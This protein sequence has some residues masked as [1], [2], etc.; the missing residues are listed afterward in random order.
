MTDAINKHNKS[1]SNI[2]LHFIINIKMISIIALCVAFFLTVIFVDRLV[3]RRLRV[4]RIAQKAIL[5][6]GCDSGF[7]F[8]LALKCLDNGMTVFASC[9]TQQ[10]VDLLQSKSVKTATGR[11][12]AFIMDVTSDISVQRGVTFVEKTLEET[13]QDLYNLINN[14]G[15]LGNSAF[16]D[17]LR[18]ED[19]KEVVEVNTY[20]A[21]RVTH[22]FKDLIKA[23]RQEL[24]LFG[25]EVIII[26]PGFFSTALINYEKVERMTKT[27]WE[28]SSDRIRQQYGNEFIEKYTNCA[29]KLLSTTSSTHTEWVVNAYYHAATARFPYRYYRIGYD[30]LLVFV[31]FSYMPPI[32]QDF[33]V[34]LVRTIVGFPVP[35]VTKASG[36]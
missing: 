16:D 29:I 30:S 13:N 34:W 33:I 36:R 9:R 18:L 25:V 28:Q 26:E 14:A 12:Y 17:F 24:R 15:I 22:A 35:A 11:L 27:L 19:Y 3:I 8:D 23:S 4:K 2:I 20:G 7:G 6:T 10:G 31:P 32:L 5:I 21:I 1:K